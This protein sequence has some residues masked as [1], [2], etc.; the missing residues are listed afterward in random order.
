MDTIEITSEQWTGFNV[1]NGDFPNTL[2]TSDNGQSLNNDNNLWA[3]NN[4][5][6]L[7]G[8]STVDRVSY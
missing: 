7:F 5:C 1:P 4:G 3:E 8:G 2:L 6:L